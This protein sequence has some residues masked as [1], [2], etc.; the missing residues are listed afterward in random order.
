MR[1]SCG[2]SSASDVIS[3]EEAMGH[4]G[5]G[6]GT[7]YFS[8]GWRRRWTPELTTAARRQGGRSE[9]PLFHSQTYTFG[10]QCHGAC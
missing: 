8:I 9:P 5:V 1:N 10:L 3:P 2:T 4:D 6:G 7:S